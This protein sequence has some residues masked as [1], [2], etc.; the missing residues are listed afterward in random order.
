MVSVKL[1]GLKAGVSGYMVL[2]SF[3]GISSGPK[4]L[5]LI[6]WQLSISWQSACFVCI[7][8]WV[9]FLAPAVQECADKDRHLAADWHSAWYFLVSQVGA[10]EFSTKCHFMAFPITIQLRAL[11]WR[12]QG[13]NLAPAIC[14]SSALQLWSYKCA[15]YWIRLS[16]SAAL[17]QTDRGSSEHWAKVFPITFHPRTLTQRC[18]GLNL[19][20][21][22]CQATM[23][24]YWMQSMDFS[25]LF[26]ES[27]R[28]Q[29]AT[30]FAGSSG[31]RLLLEM[32]ALNYENGN[33]PM[34]P[35]G[36]LHSWST[37]SQPQPYLLRLYCLE[38][39][40]VGPGAYTNG[41]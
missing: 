22:A 19:G 20:L 28:R 6:L 4:K 5:L 36:F 18:W 2:G 17:T 32:S 10:S 38:T 14:E 21:S 1:I 41:R 8:V 24:P 13:L 29:K 7:R 25:L 35:G 3:S 26:V 40:L 16:V 39:L 30:Y 15:F 23:L 33:I 11:N 37:P 9:R 31:H 27:Q 34:F 12:H